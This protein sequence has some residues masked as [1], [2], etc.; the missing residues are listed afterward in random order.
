MAC[1]RC[2]ISFALLATTAT[3]ALVA[4]CA[5]Q[6]YA[7]RPL[8]LAAEQTRRAAQTL[9]APALRAYLDAHGVRPLPVQTWG[10]SE[11]TLTAFFYR[12]ALQAARARGRAARETALQAARR[13]PPTVRPLVEHHSASNAADTPWSLGFEVELPLVLA[14][15]RE[16]LIRRAQAE[17][18]AAEL[19]AGAMAW[20]IRSD[21]RTRLLE[22]AAA[23]QRL[24]SFEAEIEAQRAVVA[25]L[26]KRRELGYAAS[27]D[28][29][30]AR[31]R[32]SDAQAAFASTRS[33]AQA[34]LGRLAEATGVPLAA[35]EAAQLSFADF[36]VLPDAPPASE[37]RTRALQNRT[38]LRRSLLEFEAADAAVKLQIAQQY[39]TIALR[40]GYLWD[41]G[42]N[43]WSLALDLALPG[44]LEHAVRATEARREAAAQQAL[45]TQS[46]VLGEIDTRRAS[47]ET[48][49]AAAAASDAAT[50]DQSVRAQQMQ[51]Q[52]D[53][54]QIDRLEYTLTRIETLRAQRRADAARAEA[55]RAL[56]QLEDAMQMPI[57][58]GPLPTAL[59][60]R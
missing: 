43:V 25:M 50:R 56:G 26:E 38:D 34:A 36:G 58:G 40:P 30:T 12:P 7:A 45:A 48:L 54:G 2:T 5:R 3:I 55:Q 24:A 44:R 31:I 18:E 51:R 13:P 17:A 28:V 37:T 57:S 49:H 14:S 47:Y 11:L 27:T 19:E 42:D 59:H 52:F 16:P 23:R 53:I 35:L 46:S 32:L 8:D 6:P 60:A 22:L 29:D 9:E 20:Q 21:V 33:E 1:A 41:Q 15:R 10:L 39:P 4:G